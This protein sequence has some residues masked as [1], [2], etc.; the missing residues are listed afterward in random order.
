M[1]RETSRHSLQGARWSRAPAPDPVQAA[2]G[3][4]EATGSGITTHLLQ[5]RSLRPAGLPAPTP[6]RACGHWKPRH[7]GPPI[8]PGGGPDRLGRASGLA[9][10]RPAP[11]VVRTVSGR[12][13]GPGILHKQGEWGSDSQ[14]SA[15]GCLWGPVGRKDVLPK[16]S[17]P[18][19]RPPPQSH[20]LLRAEGQAQR[21]DRS[22]G[23]PPGLPDGRT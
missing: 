2:C 15:R 5:H 22:P 14:G 20:P 18:S 3:H 11:L 9:V 13:L 7:P 1:R 6:R 23:W 8:S 12:P 19:L 21:Q 17:F 4:L 16:G 10:V